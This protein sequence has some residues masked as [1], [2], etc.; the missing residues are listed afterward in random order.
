M[1][2]LVESVSNYK[3]QPGQQDLKKENNQMMETIK[4]LQEK[5]LKKENEIKDII[6]H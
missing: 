4:E 6:R 2:C 3:F 1:N 5:L